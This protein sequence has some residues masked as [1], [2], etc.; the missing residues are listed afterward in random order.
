M[1][2]YSC[3]CAP[4][5]AGA[6]S[7]AVLKTVAVG[8]A[9]VWGRAVLTKRLVAPRVV[10]LT[11]YH[12]KRVDRIGVFSCALMEANVSA[13]MLESTETLSTEP[14]AFSMLATHA[15]VTHRTWRTK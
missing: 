11:L 6:T 14:C 1:N 3:R 13:S 8:H 9:R 5:R 2:G 7:G 15:A 10:Y 12:D 4:V